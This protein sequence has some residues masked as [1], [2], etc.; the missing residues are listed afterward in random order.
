MEGSGTRRQKEFSTF[1]IQFFSFP[2]SDHLFFP[3]FL[4]CLF[5]RVSYSEKHER[6]HCLTTV[7][8]SSFI[9]NGRSF[10]ENRQRLWLCEYTWACV[11]LELG[12]CSLNIPSSCHVSFFMLLSPWL[13]NGTFTFQVMA[14]F[15][16]ACLLCAFNLDDGVNTQLYTRGGTLH[17][18]GL[19]CR[20]FDTRW[21]ICSFR[22]PGVSLLD[23]EGAGNQER[24][25]H[26]SCS[27]MFQLMCL[28]VICSFLSWL[29]RNIILVCMF[30]FLLHSYPL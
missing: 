29:E 20:D 8:M 15:F 12:R 17:S 22:A 27:L 26:S 10:D 11:P 28:R 16:I 21:S 4:Y 13:F 24:K 23:K 3:L 9:L 5:S 18:V 1:F 19:I 25:F 30:S 14:V 6:A 2:S 7:T